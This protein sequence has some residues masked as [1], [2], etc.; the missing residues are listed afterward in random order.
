MPDVRKLNYEDLKAKVERFQL[1]K[2]PGQPQ[3]MHMGAAY[4]V[5]DLMWYINELRSALKEAGA[6]I[7]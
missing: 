1:M 5:S 3:A 6:T 7:K 2:L 4:L